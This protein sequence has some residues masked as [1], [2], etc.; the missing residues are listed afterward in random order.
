MT[1]T[2]TTFFNLPINK[3]HQLYRSYY[4]LVIYIPWWNTPDEMFL[5]E[6]VRKVLGNSDTHAEIDLVVVVVVLVF[7]VKWHIEL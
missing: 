5:S 1:T 7:G 4:E 6:D 3:R 2:Q